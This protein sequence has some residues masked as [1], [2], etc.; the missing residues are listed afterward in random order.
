LWGIAA[1]LAAL[2]WGSEGEEECSF[3]KKRTKKL[4]RAL[5]GPFR[6]DTRQGTK[7]FCFFFSK[8]KAFLP[9]A[10]SSKR[11]ASRA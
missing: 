3:L 10:Q 7:V 9:R 8:K 1:L 6:T 2:G 4:L 5:S 11:A